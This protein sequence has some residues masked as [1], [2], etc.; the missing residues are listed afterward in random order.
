MTNSN[1]RLVVEQLDRKLMKFQPLTTVEIPT[2]GWIN[3][4]RRSLNMSLA[5]LAK[6]LGKT[7]A[8]VKE[9][10]ERDRKSVV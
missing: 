7:P 4:I 9:I 3:A 2:E 1:R 6:R 8:T 10:E 5:Q